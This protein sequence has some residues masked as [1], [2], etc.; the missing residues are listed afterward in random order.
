MD[1]HASRLFCTARK[2]AYPAGWANGK[3]ADWR[4]KI[5]LGKGLG[6]CQGES[7][8]ETSRNGRMNNRNQMPLF[9]LANALVYGHSRWQS[10]LHNA[11]SLTAAIAK[12]WNQAGKRRMENCQPMAAGC[13][14]PS[15]RFKVRM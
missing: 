10:G 9:M 13:S 7:G 3:A 8:N 5:S 2:T 15:Q 14:S 1:I 11:I 12:P 6:H 4:K